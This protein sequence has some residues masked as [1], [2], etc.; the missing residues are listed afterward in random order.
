MNIRENAEHD[1]TFIF[2]NIQK[3]ILLRP[4][5]DMRQSYRLT[6]SEFESPVT[7]LTQKVIIP[8]V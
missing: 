1:S 4:H 3:I 5:D 2:T 6:E 7:M 8:L